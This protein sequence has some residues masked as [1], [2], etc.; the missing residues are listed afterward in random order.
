MEMYTKL[1]AQLDRSSIDITKIR[2]D[3]R[4]DH[5]ASDYGG[6]REVSL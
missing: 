5:L 3:V 4:M 1:L 2:A 6:D